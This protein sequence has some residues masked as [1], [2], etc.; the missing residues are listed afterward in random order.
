MLCSIFI[1][2]ASLL[3]LRQEER[4][5]NLSI[6]G[7]NGACSDLIGTGEM[8]LGH[9][10]AM[11]IFDGASHKHL[12]CVDAGRQ[13]H[14]RDPVGDVARLVNLLKKDYRMAE[15]IGFARKEMAPVLLHAAAFSNDIRSMILVEP[16]SSFQVNSN[17]TGL[18]NP[19]FIL[20]TLPGA[21]RAYDLP[22]LAAS[23]APRRLF[24]SG[25][26][27]GNGTALDISNDLEI[28]KSAY[29]EGI[30]KQGNNYG[31]IMP[32]SWFQ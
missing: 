31:R 5:R 23:F 17:G 6:Q 11:H 22:D 27:D 16:Y 10:K 1:R 25:T 9:L 29:K 24:I 21:L 2:Q 7:I 20:S 3:N 26:I 15:I 19:Q 4:L 18:Y 12:V 8:G 28:I 14:Y 30:G 13:K 32:E